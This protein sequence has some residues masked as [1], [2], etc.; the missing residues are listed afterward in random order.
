VV[1]GDYISGDKVGSDKV[2]GDKIDAREAQGVVNRPSGEA[3]GTRG[4][5]AAGTRGGEA[6]GMRGGEAAGM[7][8]GEGLPYGSLFKVK[9]AL[10]RAQVQ[11]GPP[12]DNALAQLEA[13]LQQVPRSH[14]QQAEA[15]AASIAAMADAV[16]SG[17]PDLDSL[18]QQAEHLEQ[19]TTE[20]STAH[21]EIADRARD[22][23]MAVA[24]LLD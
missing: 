5:E 2:G 7:R 23:V 10:K 13:A 9:A 21:P 19:I 4:G 11:L 14:A 20:L 22:F 8:G 24:G 17:S 3:A 12:H 6:A 18:G 15:L 1:Y 16:A